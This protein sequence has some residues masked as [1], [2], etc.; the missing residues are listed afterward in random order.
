MA[1][2]EGDGDWSDAGPEAPSTPEQAE[3]AA[4]GTAEATGA[5]WA[6]AATAATATA[7]ATGASGGSKGKGN[8]KDEG[9]VIGKRDSNGN[10]K[11]T[12]NGKG[13]G[14]PGG[15]AAPA[16]TA[17]AEAEAAATADD[18]KGM[19]GGRGTGAG[20][21]NGSGN[22]NGKG[23]GNGR[24]KRRKKGAKA[25][26]K[27]LAE[28]GWLTTYHSSEDGAGTP[29]EALGAA[30]GAVATPPPS[31][32]LP[33][34]EREEAAE[35]KEAETE[36]A[37]RS[38]DA[39]ARR[40]AAELEEEGRR[41]ERRRQQACL[42]DSDCES[43]RDGSGD[44]RLLSQIAAEESALLTLAAAKGPTRHRQEQMRGRATAGGEETEKKEAE[45]DEAMEGLQ[46]VLRRRRK[47]TALRSVLSSEEELGAAARRLHGRVQRDKEV[48]ARAERQDQGD[49]HDL[50]WT[51]EALQERQA[52]VRKVR[53]KVFYK[54]RRFGVRLQGARQGGAIPPGLRPRAQRRA[55]TAEDKLAQ[56]VQRRGEAARRELGGEGVGRDTPKAEHAR[57][58]DEARSAKEKR[59]GWTAPEAAAKERA[60]RESLR[61]LRS[62]GDAQEVRLMARGHVP[63]LAAGATATTAAAERGRGRGRG[64]SRGDG[65]AVPHLR[66]VR[67][68]ERAPRFTHFK[69]LRKAGEAALD[70]PSS[71]DGAGRGGDGERSRGAGGT[72]SGSRTPRGD[73]SDSSNSGAEASISSMDSSEAKPKR[74]GRPKHNAAKAKAAATVR[75]RQRELKTL[76]KRQ[77]AERQWE[78][79]FRHQEGFGSPLA[80]LPMPNRSD[81]P[82]TGEGMVVDTANG[83]RCYIGRGSLSN[84]KAWQ[85][86]FLS[87]E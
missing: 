20:T 38:Q 84:S 60:V 45:K 74:A 40:Q 43:V 77:A 37:E 36:A 12:G 57:A 66:E 39:A 56:E 87:A 70:L 55:A 21:G 8:G 27:Q 6:K 19:G 63:L 85:Q 11:G 67:K 64:G 44:E 29:G 18:G 58:A 86:D 32:T 17:P 16:A 65:V 2:E 1:F 50:A 42:A 79:N 49:P 48:Q 41:Q 53:E 31:E 13:R 73:R 15:D 22:G 51:Y 59:Q 25:E 26:G 33:A 10:G 52:E 61:H 71:D 9:H 62:G 47:T 75:Q 72:R 81:A 24:G 3:A 34:A 80:W 30:V 76:E 78:S 14:T 7:D 68:A 46:S 35:R 54:T 82:P 28:R 83:V 23:N 4:A 5:A 69:T